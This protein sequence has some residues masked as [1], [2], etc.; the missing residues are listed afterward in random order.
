MTDEGHPGRP[1]KL[2]PEYVC[3][4][5]NRLERIFKWAINPEDWRSMNRAMIKPRDP[6]EES[7]RREEYSKLLM[8]LNYSDLMGHCEPAIN[9]SLP[10][11]NYPDLILLWQYSEGILL[12]HEGESGK[13]LV[14]GVADESVT[15][16]R[17][18]L[19]RGR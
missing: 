7:Q 3:D 6:G 19:H 4:Q 12:E 5:L 17:S 2:Q 15:A 9:Q 8:N 16:Q 13:G 11:S 18:E 14:V 10:A 1:K